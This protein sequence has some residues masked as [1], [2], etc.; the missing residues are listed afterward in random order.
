[1]NAGRI[2]SRLLARLRSAA[3]LCR[4]Q[5]K[6]RATSLPR[7]QCRFFARA[8]ITNYIQIHPIYV[9]GTTNRCSLR[10]IEVDARHELTYVRCNRVQQWVKENYLLNRR[11]SFN[12]IGANGPNSFDGWR[13]C[14]YNERSKESVNSKIRFGNFR[15][16]RHVIDT[17]FVFQV[18]R[19]HNHSA[20]SQE[21]YPIGPI[22]TYSFHYVRHVRCQWRTAKVSSSGPVPNRPTESTD[23]L[24]SFYRSKIRYSRFIDSNKKYKEYLFLGFFC[25]IITKNRYLL[26]EN[27]R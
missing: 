15:N 9:Y 8:R 21:L 23:V 22:G 10:E 14:W 12:R 25:V 1:M 2:Y 24:N 13:E 16:L 3:S 17:L 4:T 27:D 7:D 5:G 19:R 26:I 11:Q 18:F 6:H 20:G